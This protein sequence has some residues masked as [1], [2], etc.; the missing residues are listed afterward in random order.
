VVECEFILL[1]EAVSQNVDQNIIEIK[2]LDTRVT[3]TDKKVESMKKD[4]SANT[5][6]IAQVKQDVKK[7]GE[8]LEELKEV[9]DETVEKV[10]DLD[11]KVCNNKL[12]LM[13]FFSGVCFLKRGATLTQPIFAI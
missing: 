7:Q 10:E 2:Q 11:H 1:L 5:Q 6:N 3:T 13:L 4:V 8:Q 12:H 9:V